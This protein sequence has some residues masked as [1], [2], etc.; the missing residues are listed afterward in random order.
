L[1][2]LLASPRP[3]QRLLHPPQ[4]RPASP[5]ILNKRLTAAGFRIESCPLPSSLWTER[6]TGRPWLTPA[7]DGV[8]LRLKVTPKAAKAGLL[9]VVVDAA[10]DQHLAVR[11]TAAAEDGKANAA[12]LKL[13]AKALGI[14]ASRL[15]ITAGAQ[16][17]QKTVTIVGEPALLLDRLR[18][19]A[20]AGG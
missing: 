15:A 16:A 13:L 11:V 8:S 18:Q 4:P 2:G 17:R 1:P 3:P 12:V 5:I 14:A 10:G 9:G 20:E 6:L 19:I 7:P